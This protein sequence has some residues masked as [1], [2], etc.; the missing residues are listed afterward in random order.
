MASYMD[1]ILGGET[2]YSSY[3]DLFGHRLLS[4]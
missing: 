3:C 2:L 1:V 4:W